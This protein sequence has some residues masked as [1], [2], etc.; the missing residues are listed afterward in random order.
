MIRRLL[1]ILPPLAVVVLFA[2][3][4][5]LRWRETQSTDA[6]PHTSQ[7][8]VR[9]ENCR[10][11]DSST[12]DGD[13][14]VV[15]HGNRSHTFRIYFVDCPETHQDK[16]YETRLKDQAA[17]FSLAS[18]E[19]ATQVGRAAQ[20]ATAQWLSKPFTVVTKWERVFDSH[21]F[22]AQILV[23]NEHGSPKDLAELLIE[24]GYARIFTKGADLPGAAHERPFKNHLR[25]LESA[26]KAARRGAW[27]P[28]R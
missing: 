12:N 3:L 23:R 26:S 24:H 16:L 22:Y 15:A 14:F 28:D 6:P 1:T 17:Y 9:L 20:A 25:T 13:S 2:A 27:N 21:R 5:L 4:I 11:I 19:A 7:E 18:V 8:W 10:L